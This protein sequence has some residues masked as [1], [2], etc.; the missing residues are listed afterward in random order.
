MDI[1]TEKDWKSEEWGIDSKGAFDNFFGL[2]LTEAESRIADHC[3]LYWEDLMH[4]PRICFFY[5]FHAYLNFIYSELSK[6]ESN[7]PEHLYSIIKYRYKDILASQNELNKKVREALNFV[8]LNQ[9]HFRASPDV[10]GDLSER[11]KEIEALLGRE[12]E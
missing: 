10:Y 7:A 9:A 2:N 4:M 5:Y 1:P 3:D 11:S 6:N 12:E 8:G